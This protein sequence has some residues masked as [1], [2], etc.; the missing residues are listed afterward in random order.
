MYWRIGRQIRALRKHRRW[1]Q[2]DLA[3]RIGCSRELISRIENDRLDNVPAGKVRAC[4]EELGG[5]LRVEVQWH[6]ERLPRLMD[7]RHAALQNRFAQMLQGWGWEVRAEVS[8]NHYGDR[9][10]IDVLGW[11]ATTRTVGVT[12]IKPRL[13]DAQETLGRLDIKA[14]IARTV[15]GDL[16]WAPTRIVPMLVLDEGATQRRHVAE[17]AALFRRYAIRGRSALSWL[18]TPDGTAP[19]GLLLFLS[20]PNSHGGDTRRDRGAS[21]ARLPA[22]V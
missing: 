15:A 6:G 18:R 20:S 8:F 5:Y 16:G 14:R 12:E 11:H 1:R 21:A 9:G 4:V 3:G 13:G 19:S 10:R 7:A 2:E 17:H 22:A